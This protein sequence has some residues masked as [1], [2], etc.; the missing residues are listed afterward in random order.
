MAL[1]ELLDG[2]TSLEIHNDL[3]HEITV[4]TAGVHAVT[5][6]KL[7]TCVSTDL[8]VNKNK[9]AVDTKIASIPTPPTPLT[10]SRRA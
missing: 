7:H 6:G 1:L 10:F 8:P 5:L 9:N 2:L 3:Q 4:A